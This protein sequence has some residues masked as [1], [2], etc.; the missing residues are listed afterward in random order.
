MPV[1]AMVWEGQASAAPAELY[2]PPKPHA[3]YAT[4]HSPS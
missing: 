4:H 3:P 2:A 1:S